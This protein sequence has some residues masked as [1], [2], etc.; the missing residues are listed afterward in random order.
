MDLSEMF[1]GAKQLLCEINP[2]L[3]QSMSTISR[4]VEILPLLDQPVAP[5]IVTYFQRQRHDITHSL[6]SSLA[7]LEAFAEY[8]NITFNVQAHILVELIGRAKDISPQGPQE[9]LNTFRELFC[10]VNNEDAS[11]L[12]GALT[13]LRS[14]CK[15][16]AEKDMSLIK[17]YEII[18]IVLQKHILRILLD[19]IMG[20]Y[21]GRMRKM[22]L[23]HPWGQ[24]DRARALRENKILFSRRGRGESAVAVAYNATMA[25]HVTDI[26]QHDAYSLEARG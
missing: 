26:Y 19:R 17:L 2:N 12:K 15:I 1:E 5:E 10:V 9:T 22:S 7:L 8:L 23:L 25:R 21:E 16:Y 14:L 6:D 13:S 3:S 4:G 20:D 24:S 11:R 18:G